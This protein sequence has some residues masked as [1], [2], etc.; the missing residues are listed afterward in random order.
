MSEPEAGPECRLTRINCR[1]GWWR[2]R[3]GRDGQR[4][5]RDLAHEQLRPADFDLIATFSCSGPSI[6]R[7]LTTVPF[8]DPRSRR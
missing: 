5:L 7:P 2:R 4:R 3:I 8:V 1:L 6:S